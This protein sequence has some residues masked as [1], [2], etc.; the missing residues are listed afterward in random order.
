M[1]TNFTSRIT[2]AAIIA[3][4]GLTASAQT[5]VRNYSLVYT[6]NIRGGVTMLGNTSTHILNGNGS[7][8]TTKMN[9]IGNA[10][11]GQGGIGFTQYGNDN[12][13][14]QHADM[15]T[16]AGTR[17]STSADL[18]LPA[19]T[20]TI[21][22]ARLYWGG[23]IS[24]AT[25]TANPD[26]LRKIKLRKG[27][28][29]AYSPATAPAANV[30]QFLISGTSERVYQSYVDIT[31]FVQV[32]GSG[33]YFVADVPLTTGS[34]SN[35]GRFGGW[36][37][38]VAYENQ[39]QPY[40]S[41]RVYDGYSQI[42]NSSGNPVTST[43]TLTG[44]NVP[45]NPLASNEAVMSA[46]SW[47]GDGSLGA[48]AVNPAGDFIKVNNIAVSNAA[49][50]VTNFWNGSIT[51][52][53]AYVTTKNP[54][55]FNQMGIDIDEV[56]VGTGYGIQPNA[57]SVNITFGT[58][59]D[60]YFPSAFSFMIRM[61]DPLIEL[62]KTVTDANSDGFVNSNEILT[63]TLSGVNNGPGT[64]YNAVVVD[65]LPSNVT[66]VAGSMEVVSAPGVT[67][68]FKTDA[69]GDD[70]A[71][72][73]TANGKTYLKFYIGNGATSAAG[74]QIPVGSTY[75]IRFK[76]QGA[77]IPG[78]VI[79]T[80]RIYSSS[81]VGDMFTD[82]GTAV[83]APAG[84]PL[85][86][87][88]GSF[89]ASLLTSNSTLVKWTTDSEIN[90]SHFEVERSED[91]VRFSVRGTVTG[92]GTT[93]TRKNYSFTDNIDSRARIFYYRLKSVDNM[94][95]HTYSKIIAV[96]VD[97]GIAANQFSI[98]PNPFADHVKISVSSSNESIATFRVLS[99]DG[100]EVLNRKITLTNGDNIVVMNDLGKLQ[101]GSYI[102]EVS[103]GT[104]KFIKKIVK[105]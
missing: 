75:T 100:K 34:T 69:A 14:I 95:K 68:G 51:K 89:T 8:N 96:R 41:V 39:S 2:L 15:D 98:Y 64:A 63:Y 102:L 72:K 52:N 19:G 61:K 59:A 37:I 80:A 67:A 46:M 31:N 62:N 4:T 12:E 16:D 38:V 26:T 55:Y 10:A 54:N 42:F 58:E 49:N 5:S 77:L 93:S 21:K 36:C 13:N 60:Q 74:G 97:G 91:G 86:V 44:L 35:G 53:G 85:D 6:E 33:T 40:Y 71:F 104:D 29:G 9:E 25:V 11:N 99:F 81:Q 101:K 30:D 47:E 76:V 20:N 17:N 23:R 28:I 84:G 56:N 32:G 24:N 22:F 82:D 65:T 103:T 27:A 105:Q 94:G 78:S 92:N 43:V 70:V 3:C 90:H 83:I 45:N 7:V 66:Y 87:K 88:L 48:T 50:P 18:T 79:N 73:G 1:L 57:T